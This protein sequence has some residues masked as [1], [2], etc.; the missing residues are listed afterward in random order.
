MGTAGLTAYDQR[1]FDSIRQGCR[2]SAA[3]LVPHL[4]ELYPRKRRI[5]DV[6]C[7]EGHFGKAFGDAGGAV[8]GVDGPEARPIIEHQVADLREPL[9]LDRDF[10]LAL[11][12]EVAEHLPAARAADFVDELCTLAPLVVFSA[13]V[14]GQGGTGHLNEQW[15]GYWAELFRRRGFC[16]SGALRWRIWED[17]R[18]CWW[19]RQNLMVFAASPGGLGLERDGCPAVVHPAM[20]AHHGCDS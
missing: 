6:G 9:W 13:A 4:L 10:D 20:W 2:S 19:Y 1:F 16:G 14:P 15:P 7:G 18:I 17:D 5:V 11:C 3:A 8:L 12:L